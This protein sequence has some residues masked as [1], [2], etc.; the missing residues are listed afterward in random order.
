MKQKKK[1]PEFFEE[2]PK[3]SMDLSPMMMTSSATHTKIILEPI[4]T[5]HFQNVASVA[6]MSSTTFHCL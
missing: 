4:Q 1:V 6:D 5:F 2:K 3:Q